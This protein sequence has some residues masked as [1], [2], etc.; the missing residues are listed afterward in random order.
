MR[1]TRQRGEFMSQLKNDLC[2]LKICVP[3]DAPNCGELKFHATANAKSAPAAASD[4]KTGWSETAYASNLGLPDEE[5]DYDEFVKEE[6]GSGPAKPRGIHWLWWLVALL[7]DR[8]VS[9]FCL[10]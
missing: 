2:R 10:H 8:I 6:F 1:N 9:I 5:F 7:L 3:T 4:E